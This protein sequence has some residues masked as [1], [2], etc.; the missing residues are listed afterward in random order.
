MAM[1]AG[2][3]ACTLAVDAAT[4]QS[5]PDRTAREIHAPQPDI[6]PVMETNDSSRRERFEAL[7]REHGDAVYRFALRRDP[8]S[9]DDVVAE[10]FLIAWRRLDDVPVD[11]ELPWLL[12]VARRAYSNAWRG[13][14][15]RAALLER[16]RGESRA[17]TP[18]HTQ[19][20]PSGHAL[21]SGVLESA[22]A[23]LPAR[24]RELLMLVAWDELDP[25]GVAQAMGCSRANV[26]VRLHRARK[27]LA[28]ELDRLEPQLVPGTRVEEE[29]SRA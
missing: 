29:G 12:G 27:R 15:R 20:S 18:D 8:A 6:K 13:E 11:A 5:R 21:L 3:G 16:L 23:C 4:R 22:L 10:S 17:S 26:A 7:F 1:S 19:A 25:S 28:R 14:R 2:G 9:A 24:D